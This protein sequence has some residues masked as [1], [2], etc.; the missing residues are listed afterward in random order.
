M[1]SAVQKQLDRQK[2]EICKAILGNNELTLASA[3][4]LVILECEGY[5]TIDYY[6]IG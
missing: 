6:T 2:L 1:R 4:A 5:S 3:L